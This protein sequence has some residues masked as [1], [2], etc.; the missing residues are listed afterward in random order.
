MASNPG[1]APY[2][3]EGHSSLCLNFHICKMGPI[4]LANTEYHYVPRTVQ[5]TYMLI[6]S[7]FT[8]ETWVG[9]AMMPI[10]QM[11]KLR[12]RKVK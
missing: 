6:E 11:R 9:I 5:S 2:E 4:M 7:T 10:S 8:M 12:S 3:L 1:F